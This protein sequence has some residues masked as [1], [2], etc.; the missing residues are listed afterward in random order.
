VW[1]SADADGAARRAWSPRVLLSSDGVE[2]LALGMQDGP[3]GAPAGDRA[4][5]VAAWRR[6]STWSFDRARANRAA[7]SR[8]LAAASAGTPLEPLCR[9]LAEHDAVQRLS[10]PW[11]TDAQKIELAP[12]ALLSLREAALNPWLDAHL[13]TYVRDLWEGL[14]LTLAGKREI[15]LI[16]EHVEPLAEAYP[17]WPALERVLAYADS[18]MLDPE[19]AAERLRRVVERD[20]YDLAARLDRARA[21]SMANR[22]AEAAAELRA[23]LEVQPDRQDVRRRLA[24][25]LVRANDPEGRPMVEELCLEDPDDEELRVYLGSGP[26]PPLH[27]E[28]TVSGGRHDH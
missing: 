5:P 10:S 28:F 2:R 23:V 9:G 1:V 14:A 17:P 16:Y 6:A 19:G 26:F 8:R 20:P 21:L 18:E 7:V 15:D 13:R 11:E 12:Q 25:A 3:L 24:V 27:A 4:P 22:P